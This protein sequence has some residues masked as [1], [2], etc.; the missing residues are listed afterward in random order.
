MALCHSTK[1]ALFL[2]CTFDSLYVWNFG[3]FGLFK[4]GSSFF[5][6]KRMVMEHIGAF[7]TLR[8]CIFAVS[9]TYGTAHMFTSHEHMVS[10]H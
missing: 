2:K 10:A 6:M 7:C 8:R 5:H 1:V 4:L 9:R 3:T